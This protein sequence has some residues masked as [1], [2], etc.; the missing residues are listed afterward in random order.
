MSPVIP[1]P[2][3]SNYRALRALMRTAP[4]SYPSTPLLLPHGCCS[5]V[6]FIK[7]IWQRGYILFLK[8]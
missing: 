6:S 5:E 8:R 1:Y 7:L 3:S 2:S 4:F